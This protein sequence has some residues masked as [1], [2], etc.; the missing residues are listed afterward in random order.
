MRILV[1]VDSFKGSLTAD[2]AVHWL[3]QGLMKGA[4]VEVDPCPLADGGE[5]TSALVERYL[6]G[7]RVMAPTVDSFGRPRPG[8]WVRWGRTAVVESA[9]GSGYLPPADRPASVWHTTS[10]GTG[11]LVHHAQQA[12]DIDRVIVTLGGTGAV[13]GGMGFLEALGVEFYDR[14]GHRLTGMAG[15]LERVHRIRWPDVV[16]PIVGLYDTFVPLLGPTGAVRLYGPQKGVT[17]QDVEPFERHLAHFAHV[18]QDS[19]NQSDLTNRPGAGAAGGMGLAIYALGGRLEAGAPAVAQWMDLASRL[20]RA[21]WVITGEGR[22]DAQ[23][24]LG[25][26]VGTVLDQARA[27][28]R[29]VL[30]VA[31]ALPA[32]LSPFYQAGLTAAW[33]LV[34][35]PMTVEEAMR[36]APRLL[37]QLGE[38]FARLLMYGDSG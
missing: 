35:G 18:L 15:H 13:D 7:R 20:E 34:S 9:V 16:P 32:D 4:R 6:G 38:N 25:K 29:P 14:D 27:R 33:P 37:Q 5:G 3:S 1:A 11:M 23:S 30:A 28:Y 31:G 36:D 22:L 17:P 12:P 26:V 21:D 19:L 24:L 2:E 10:R 8:W